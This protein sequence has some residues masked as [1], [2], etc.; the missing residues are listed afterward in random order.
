[1]VKNLAADAG[2]M[3]DACSIPVLG[4]PPGGRNGN[5]LQFSCLENPVDRGS[6]WA[7]VYGATESQT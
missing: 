5:S 4:R 1:M 2:G 7:T 3:R 6:L